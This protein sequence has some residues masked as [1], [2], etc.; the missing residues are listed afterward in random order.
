MQ[1]DFLYLQIDLQTVFPDEILSFDVF[2][3]TID[4][5]MDICCAKGNCSGQEKLDKIR[6][7]FDPFLYINK[8]NLPEYICI[9][10]ENAKK[11][12]EDE[13]A[14]L[15][16]KVKYAFAVITYSAK[17]IFANPVKEDISKFKN[18]LYV[19]LN[20]LQ[21]DDRAFKEFLKLT[22]SNFTLMNHNINVGFIGIG[23]AKKIFGAIQKE[24]LSDIAL[25]F[26]LHDIGKLAISKDILL[27]KSRF[28]QRRM[29]YDEKT[30]GNRL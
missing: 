29:A 10:Q 5:R 3:K 1:P 28:K 7:S 30:S 8:I 15:E 17:N 27:K 14:S 21:N 16:R 24:T 2:H 22:N 4:G 6:D 11:V 9:L 20:N 25:G 26:F 19:T 13:N 23:I 12:M 18:I